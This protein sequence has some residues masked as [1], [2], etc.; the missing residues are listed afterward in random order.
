MPPSCKQECLSVI[1]PAFSYFGSYTIPY[2]DMAL[3]GRSGD[4][5]LSKSN[6]LTDFKVI[7]PFSLPVQ[8]QL[9]HNS[10]RSIVTGMKIREGWILCVHRR[11]KCCICSISCSSASSSGVHLPKEITL[12]TS[13]FLCK[14]A[15][16]T[17]A[18]SKLMM[19]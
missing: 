19:Q 3:F 12:H 17:P 10:M 5:C 14:K 9:R 1:Y 7:S 11:E 13:A 6:V 8:S 4:F 18:P 15:A 2:G 16:L